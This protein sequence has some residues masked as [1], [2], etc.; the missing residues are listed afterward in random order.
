MGR[1]SAVFKAD[2]AETESRYSISEW[3]LEPRTQELAAAIA[4][5]VGIG[6][7]PIAG[8]APVES[9]AAVPYLRDGGRRGYA[10]FLTRLAPRAFAIAPNGERFDPIESA[11]E[12]CNR[13]GDL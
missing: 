13:R 7:K 4:G 3:W 5:G 9:V 1:I 11:L 12:H 8:I 2:D 6:T 10:D